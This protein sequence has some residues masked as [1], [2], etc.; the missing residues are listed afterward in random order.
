M[1]DRGNKAIKE[2]SP[3]CKSASCVNVVMSGF[4]DPIG[5][6]VDAKDNVYVSDSGVSSVREIPKGCHAQL[7]MV[8]IGGGFSQPLGLAVGP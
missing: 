6:R 4:N 2:M 3:N 7:C 1:N 8:A 5:A